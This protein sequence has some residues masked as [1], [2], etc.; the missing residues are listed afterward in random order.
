MLR[1]IGFIAVILSLCF[2]CDAT[3]ATDDECKSAVQQCIEGKVTAEDPPGEQAVLDGYCQNA[4]QALACLKKTKCSDS[5]VEYRQLLL[6]MEAAKYI[7]SSDDNRKIYL[8]NYDCSTN[9]SETPD[10]RRCFNETRTEMKSG[11]AKTVCGA[12][13]KLLKCM[14]EVLKSHCNEDSARVFTTYRIKTAQKPPDCTLDTSYIE[15]GF[16]RL[17]SSLT[18]SVMLIILTLVLIHR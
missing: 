2:Y 12:F 8:D 6:A 5:H 16:S 14:Y 3:E 4:T 1:I 9:A 7:C 18:S 13:N 11:D 10:A 17:S 15:N